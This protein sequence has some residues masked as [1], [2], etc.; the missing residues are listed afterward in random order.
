MAPRCKR[1]HGELDS[2]FI[3]VVWWPSTVPNIGSDLLRGQAFVAPLNRPICPQHFHTLRPPFRISVSRPTETGTS[4][5]YRLCWAC[6]LPHTAGMSAPSEMDLGDL[7]CPRVSGLGSRGLVPGPGRL[8]PCRP[9]IQPICRMGSG[10]QTAC[11]NVCFLIR[12][13][14][15]LPNLLLS[16]CP[17]GGGRGRLGVRP[18]GRCVGRSKEKAQHWQRERESPDD[19][20]GCGPRRRQRRRGIMGWVQFGEKARQKSYTGPVPSGFS[21]SVWGLV[22]AADGVRRES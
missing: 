7:L 3:N 16:C 13:H 4:A 9:V 21:C 18:D 2:S 5:T 20:T 10:R 15:T 8:P 14:G 12:R 11:V 22:V 1:Y 17:V 19:P 6:D